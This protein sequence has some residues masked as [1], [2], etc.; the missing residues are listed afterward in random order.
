MN[1]RAVN[2]TLTIHW[3]AGCA[4]VGVIGILLRKAQLSE[5]DYW[6]CL[7]VA[8]AWSATTISLINV[9]AKRMMQRP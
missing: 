3:I 8:I 5:R 6:L 4:M 1:N 2:T 9:L 7:I